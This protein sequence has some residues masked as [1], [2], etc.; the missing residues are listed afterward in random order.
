MCGCIYASDIL[1]IKWGFVNV[2]VVQLAFFTLFHGYPPMY[3]QKFPSLFNCCVVCGSVYVHHDLFN[4]TPRRM[5]S[6]SPVFFSC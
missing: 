5:Y 6:L 2:Y 4:L 1:K 3:I